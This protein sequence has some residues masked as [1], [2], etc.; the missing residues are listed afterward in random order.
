M[1]I[2][3]IIRNLF[4]KEMRA[5]NKMHRKHRKELIKLAKEDAEWDWEF[6]HDLVITKIRHMHEY[7]KE[8][9]NVWQTDETLLP[10]INEL[11]HVLDLQEEMDH[12]FDNLPAPEITFSNNPTNSMRVMSV[13]Y[14]DEVSAI[15]DRAYEREDEIYKEIYTY[16]G[17]HLRG[18]WD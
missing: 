16:I 18:W 9:N 2:F 6:L 12:L 14:S 8:S 4:N 3:R 1:K 7:Y 5:Y 15:R 17:E 11:K 10:T 13:T